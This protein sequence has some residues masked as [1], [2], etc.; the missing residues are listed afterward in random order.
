MENNVFLSGKNKSFDNCKILMNDQCPRAPGLPMG[1][2]CYLLWNVRR[3]VVTKP[4]S[5]S[6]KWVIIV[7]TIKGGGCRIL[8]TAHIQ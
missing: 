1:G 7:I 2:F 8:A 4:V 6:R 3:G 5:P